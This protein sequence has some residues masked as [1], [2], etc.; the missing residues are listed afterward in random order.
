MNGKKK[1][2]PN[3][4]EDQTGN[5]PGMFFI[6]ARLPALA[7]LNRHRYLNDVEHAT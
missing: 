1:N 2:W 4:C 6:P 5:M 3:N 7:M